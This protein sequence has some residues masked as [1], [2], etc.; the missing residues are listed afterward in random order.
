VFPELTPSAP[1]AA[2][3]PIGRPD[4]GFQWPNVGIIR[5]GGPTAAPAANVVAQVNLT[6]PANFG[7]QGLID[8]SAGPALKTFA[9]LDDAIWAARGLTVGKA[10]MGVVKQP[11]GSFT[12][13][14]LTVPDLIEMGADWNYVKDVTL[15]IG[16]DPVIPRSIVDIRQLTNA[17]AANGQLQSIWTRSGN[18]RY[19]AHDGRFDTGFNHM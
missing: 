18:T 17:P 2:G 7:A 3:A 12:V 11:N 13:N 6:F 10:S 14:E 4:D 8:V 16:P 15:I 19:D 1:G 5:R 9:T